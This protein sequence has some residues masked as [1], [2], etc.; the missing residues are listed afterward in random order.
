MKKPL[1]L[2]DF[3]HLLHPYQTFLVTCVDADGK[4]NI[5]TIAWAIPVSVVPP[6]LGISIRPTRYSYSLIKSTKEFVMNVPGIEMAQVVLYCGRNSGRDVDKFKV[7]GLTPGKA[8][9]VQAPIIEECVAHLECRVKDDVEAGDHHLIIA[10]VL[11]AHAREDV[12]TD[13]GLYRLEMAK[14]LLHM[15][16]SSFTQVSQ[17]YFEPDIKGM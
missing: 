11:T 9:Q 3:H 6:L 8:K 15:G 12:L 7:T 13:T 1:L 10:E 5:I 16:G 2:S 17:D 14:P 4:A